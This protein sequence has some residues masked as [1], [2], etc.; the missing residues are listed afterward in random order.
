MQESYHRGSW[1][2]PQSKADQP[3]QVAMENGFEDIDF[4]F[5]VRW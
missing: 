3:K 4:S 2:D 1:F 5:V